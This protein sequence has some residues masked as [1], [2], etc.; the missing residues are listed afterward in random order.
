MKHYDFR[1]IIIKNLVRPFYKKKAKKQTNLFTY[2]A[3]KDEFFL[4]PEK[5]EVDECRLGR[6]SGSKPCM[7]CF[8]KGETPKI[9][10]TKFWCK[11]CKVPVCPIDCYDQHRIE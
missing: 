1:Q 8:T 4:K 9:K 10:L 3:E 5:H 2:D 7:K 11:A 6:I